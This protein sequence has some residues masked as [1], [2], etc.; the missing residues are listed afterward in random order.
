MDDKGEKNKFCKIACSLFRKYIDCEAE[1]Q[2]NISGSL[3]R[4]YMKYGRLNWSIHTSEL[5]NIFDDVIEEMFL[6]MKQSFT[7]FQVSS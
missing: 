2:V 7:R 1:L 4:K 6:L 3:R 5:V